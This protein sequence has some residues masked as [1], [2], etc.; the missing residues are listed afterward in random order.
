MIEN[1]TGFTED[2]TIALTGLNGRLEQTFSVDGLPSDICNVT[3]RNIRSAAF[4]T[5]VRLLNQGD[6]ALHDITIDGVY[7][8]SDGLRYFDKSLYAVRVGDTRLYGTRP[9]TKEETYNITIKNVFAR[10]EYAVSL[11]GDMNNLVMY[12]IECADGCKMLLDE[13]TSGK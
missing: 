10:N 13:R 9:A 7:D 1:I 11:A 6:V 5:I 4:C 3:V 12:G 2:D 8:S